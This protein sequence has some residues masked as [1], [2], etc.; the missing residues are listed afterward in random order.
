MLR[1]V[2]HVSLQYLSYDIL[3]TYTPAP[4]STEE[5]VIEK[6]DHMI[7][8]S[9]RVSAWQLQESAQDCVTFSNTIGDFASLASIAITS[10]MRQPE[11]HL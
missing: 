10:G 4:V 8:L 6:F 2:S 7:P 1:V 3:H 11:G 9:D 5:Y